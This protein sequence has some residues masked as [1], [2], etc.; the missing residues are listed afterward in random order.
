VSAY[1]I[2]ATQAGGPDVLVREPLDLAAPGAGEVRVAIAAAGVNFIDIYHRTGAYPRS[3]PGGLGQEGAGVI[4]AVGPGVTGLVAG[5]RV[6]FLGDGAYASHVNVAAAMVFAL[7]DTVSAE[8]AAALL[9]KGLTAWMLLEGVRPV[10]SDMTVLVLAAAGGVGSLLVPWA[11]ALGATVIAHTG[12][13]AK[14]ARAAAAGAD[15]ALHDDWADLAATVR[16]LTDGRGV[17]LVLDGVGRA[18]WAA[19]LAS[20]A[21][22]GMIASYGSASGPVPPISPLDLMRGGSLFLT[23]PSLYDWIAEPAMRAAGWARLSA[24]IADGTLTPHIGLR[25]PLSEA[26]QAHQ[27]LADRATTGSII[28]IP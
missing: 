17:D 16:G 7:D 10:T 4:D 26:A 19:S 18:S 11:K 12:S 22:R 20:T 1:R 13:V 2:V 8:P 14:A 27:L 6:A 25:L 21:R 24:L 5:Q 3:F 28:L 23:R 9:L 15:H